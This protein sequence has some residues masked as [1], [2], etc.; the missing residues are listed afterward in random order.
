MPWVALLL[1]QIPCRSGLPSAVRGGFRLWAA[2]VNDRTISATAR[3]PTNSFGER[4]GTHLE[5]HDLA[6]RPLARLHVKRRSR[7]HGCPQPPALPP[8]LRIV[9]PAIQPLRVEPGR[10]RDAK[11]DPLAVL[12]HEQTF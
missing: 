7:A 11:Y 2:A 8:G 12:Q 4:I 9:D 1:I 5:V 3:T 6:G 10:V